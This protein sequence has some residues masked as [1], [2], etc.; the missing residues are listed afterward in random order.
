M[1][2]TTAGQALTLFAV[3]LALVGCR[4]EGAHEAYPREE[5]APDHSAEEVAAEGSHA[6]PQDQEAG[7]GPGGGP[8]GS[9]DAFAVAGVLGAVPSAPAVDAEGPGGEPFRVA[10]RSPEVGHYPCTSCHIRPIG[11]KDEALAQMHGPRAEHEG[12]TRVDCARCHDPFRPGGMTLDCAECHEREGVR[13]LMPSRSAHL[14]VKLSHPGGAYRNCLTCHSPENPGL[15]ALRDGGRATLDEAYLLCRGCHF[16]QGEDWAKGA[17][18][19]RLGGWAGQR[20]I[21]SCT[22]CHDPH[23]PRFPMR[24]PVTFPK[25][26][27]PGEAR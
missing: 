25:I 17:H 11:H 16:M 9:V 26:A 5:H 2:T 27:R 14:S 10:L 3:T 21:L 15:L 24:R 7:H 20:T 19:K 22:G 18:G 12:A 8:A 1:R 4:P 13:E 6:S 23:D